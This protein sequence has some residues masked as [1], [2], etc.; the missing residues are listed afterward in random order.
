MTLIVWHA[1]A[2][3]EGGGSE[4]VKFGEV[5]GGLGQ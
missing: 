4:D 3:R 2:G 1:V 5:T